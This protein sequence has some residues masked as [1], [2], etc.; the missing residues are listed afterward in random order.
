MPRPNREAEIRRAALRCFS[1]LG[2]DAT[3]VKHI[4]AEAGV[5]DAALY[6]HWKGKEELAAAIYAEGIKAYAE[7]ISELA[8]QSERTV[9]E[10]LRAIAR[11]SLQLYRSEPDAWTFLIQGQG[12]FLASLG[13]DFPYPIHVI[14]RLIAAGQADGSVRA[15]DGR[16]LAGIATGCFT[17]PVIV[18]IFARAGT[19]D[20][21]SDDAERLIA[22]ATWAAVSSPAA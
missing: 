6:A 22:D 1:R 7:T 19:V 12:R 9:E 20:P 8:G 11:A 10:R 5:S 21:T 3:R 15:G 4:A 17:Y 16:V 14:E 13:A 2:Y 18:A